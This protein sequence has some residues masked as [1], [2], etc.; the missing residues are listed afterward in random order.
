MIQILTNDNNR[1][2]TF[3]GDSI[4]HSDL[5]RPECN[6]DGGDCDCQDQTTCGEYFPFFYFFLKAAKLNKIFL[7]FISSHLSRNKQSIVWANFYHKVEKFLKG[8]MDSISSPFALMKIQIMGGKVCLRCKGKTLLGIVI[9][10]FVFKNLLTT[11]SDVL[12]LH[13]YG[14]NDSKRP[15]W[16]LKKNVM[17]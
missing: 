1:I 17:G 14:L 13:F 8:S 6:Y 16:E 10:L 2:V 7:F 5:N 15:K 12:S 3:Y 9:K 11:S 4:C